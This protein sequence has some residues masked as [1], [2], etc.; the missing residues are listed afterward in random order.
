[1]RKIVFC[2][3]TDEPTGQSLEFAAHD[4]AYADRFRAWL[5][6][7]GK[8]PADLLVNDWDAVKIVTAAE[9]EK[10][11]ALYYY[12]QRFRT[13]ALGDF[14]AIQ[15]RLAQEAYGGT[16]P[17]QANFSD[18]AVY[19]A[20]F[21]GQGVDYFELLDSPDQ[22]AVWSEDWSNGASTYQCAAFNIDLMRAAARERGQV[23][24]NFVIAHANRKPWDIKLKA[25]SELARGSKTLESFCYGPRWATHEGGPYWRTHVWQARPETWDANASLTREVG[26]VEDVLLTAMP[27]PAKVALLYSSATDIWTAEGNLAWGFDRMHTWLALAHA[28]MPVDVLSERQ[29]AQG[30]LDGYQVCYLSGPNLTLSAAEKL[31]AWVEAGGTLWLT[32]D[33]AS[34]DEFNRP[35]HVLDPILPADRAQVQEL[36]KVG[37]AGRN[38]A[39]LSAKDEVRWPGGKADVLAVRQSLAARAGV[40]TLATFGD[41]SPAAVQGKAGRGTICCVGFLPSLGYIKQALDARNELQRKATEGSSLAAAEQKEVAILE[42]SANPWKYPADLREFIL[43]PVRAAGVASPITCDVPL[44][45][46]VVMHGDVGIIIPLANYTLEPI[47]RL[48]LQVSVPRRVVK[49]ESARRGG[50]AFRQGS[51]GTVELA[52]PLENND[53]VKLYLQ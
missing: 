1:M 28:Q 21:Y 33:A 45:D 13:R 25:T 8:T 39:G 14:M 50:I 47:E 19:S 31:K 30:M 36:Q 22:N 16:F 20:N 2:R 11:P 24:G 44:V 18:G 23:V 10:L 37:A 4:A 46:A 32:A 43:S 5:K 17:V 53:F 9:R 42:R 35:L 41:K 29:A 40:T 52:M 12:S 3:L 34:R 48:T 7:L 51:S 15:A 38:L 49:A 6:Q 27:V 26:A